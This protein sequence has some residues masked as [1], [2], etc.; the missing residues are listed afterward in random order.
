MDLGCGT[1]NMTMDLGYVLP[2][3][4][5]VGLDVDRD[6]AKAWRSIHTCH[7]LLGDARTLP[8]RDNQFGLVTIFE[9]IEHIDDPGP[10][11]A[12]VKRVMTY[13]GV[14][15]VTT[16]NRDSV[17]GISGRGI[18]RA[19]GLGQWHGWNSDHKR[20]YDKDELVSVLAKSGFRKIAM[21]GFWMMPEGYQLLPKVFGEIPPMR[22][23]V[24]F[25][26]ESDLWTRAGFI[27]IGVFEKAR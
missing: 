9:M 19:L 16:P 12:E 24:S 17:T 23:F 14:L 11:L 26:S 6:A 3:A 18:K 20:L 13:D 5:V 10:L 27:L 1:G 8:F 2:D 25:S 15:A 4:T 21:A 22:G 7:Y